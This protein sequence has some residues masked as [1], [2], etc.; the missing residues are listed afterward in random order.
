[1]LNGSTGTVGGMSFLYTT[2]GVPGNQIDLFGGPV[3]SASTSTWNHYAIARV[4]SDIS[5]FVNGT[6]VGEVTTFTDTIYDATTNGS[7]GQ[8][9]TPSLGSQLP[10][11]GF[12]DGLRIITGESDYDPTAPSLPV[13]KVYYRTS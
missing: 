4:G 7:D 13:P 3:G 2:D 10:A 9:G 12:L 1:M 11:A 6:R 8:I 5:A